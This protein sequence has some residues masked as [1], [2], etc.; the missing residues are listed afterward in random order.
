LT[1]F[2]R[3]RRELVLR[4]VIFVLPAAHNLRRLLRLWTGVGKPKA[5]QG[6]GGL[7]AVFL[8]LCALLRTAGRDL[9]RWFARI[10]GSNGSAKRPTALRR[11]D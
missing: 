5:L 10:L 4:L 9:F 1:H 8:L 2:E 7:A 6:A 3:G 11:A